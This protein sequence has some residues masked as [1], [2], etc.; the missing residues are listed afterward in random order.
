MTEKRPAITLGAL[1]AALKRPFTGSLL[2][3]RFFFGVAFA[4]FQTIFSLYA[5]NKFNLTAAQTGYV[6]T[7]VGVLSV[8]TQ[9]FLVGRITK[10][11]RED[12][13]IVGSV[14]LMGISFLYSLFST[15]YSLFPYSLLTTPCS[16]QSFGASRTIYNGLP[17]ASSY[18]RPIYSPRIPS[19][20]NCTPPR[21]KT[22][23]N[24]VA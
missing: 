2:I 1:F 9:G 11:F 20:I 13:L 16:S 8:I 17:L 10:K 21:N 22:A 7:Y 5:L 4:I 18:S 19:E 24:V 23:I 15:P 14:A 6:L 12:I 3:T